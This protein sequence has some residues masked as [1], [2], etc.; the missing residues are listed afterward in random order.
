M[1]RNSVGGYGFTG[2]NGTPVS[3]GAYLAANGYSG[4]ALLTE[5]ANLLKASGSANDKGIG[6]AIASGHYTPAQLEQLYPQVFGGNY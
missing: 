4:Q 5:A 2:A 6:N 3:M 1:T